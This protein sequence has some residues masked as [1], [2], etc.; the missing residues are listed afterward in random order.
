M[1]DDLISTILTN[2]RTNEETKT[3]EQ[4]LEDD[5]KM[6]EEI[7][8]QN[9]QENLP[10]I[11]YENNGIP[12]DDIRY[13]HSGSTIDEL[14]GN[15]KPND[16][17]AFV[18]IQ[19]GGVG[20]SICATPMIESAKKYF[21]NKTIIV[22][23]AH[24]EILE[25]NPNIDHLYHLAN[26]GDL[27]E[28]WVKPLRHFGSVIKR[29]I[30]N[31]CAHKLFPGSLSMIWCHLYGVPFEGDDVKI[32]VSQ[33]EDEE[34]IRWLKSFRKPVILIH[35]SGG[36]LIHDPSVQ[37]TDNKDWDFNYWCL[38]VN[39]L[40]DKFS[41]VQVGGAGEPQIPNCTN[42]LLGRTSVR[43]TAA[44]LKN[45]VTYIGIDSFVAHCGA[46]VG[47]K[48]IVLFGRSNPYIAGHKT[49]LNI[50]VKNSCEFNDLHCGRPQGY[51]G[52]SQM[53]EGSPRPW[54]CPTRSCMKAIKPEFIFQK[55]LEVVKENI[56]AKNIK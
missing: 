18:I 6:N 53:F 55:V 3:E 21:P 49:N 39:K 46:G 42:Y 45:C 37:I 38:L 29:D 2:E 9:V 12:F 50:W 4:I 14:M 41:I 16:D 36:R 28:K 44:L 10:D 52:D 56:N 23:S 43:Q 33:G 27:F 8:I 40:I 25:N 51:F 34:A 1:K 7:D 47:K 15:N 54:S 30:Y 32:Y 31:I 22:G 35:T 13:V 19:D 5:L 11:R 17:K 48:G 24:A 26:P 20:D